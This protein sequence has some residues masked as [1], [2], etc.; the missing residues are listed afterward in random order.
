MGQFADIYV[1]VRTRSKQKATA[2]LNHFLPQRIESAGEYEYPQYSRETE[3]E[4]DTVEEL[5][6]YLETEKSAAY[7]LYWRSTDETNPNKHGMLFFTK[8]GA[9]IFGISRDAYLEEDLNTRNED[10]C[11]ELMKGYFQTDLGYIT[12]EGVP[13]DTYR[14][15]VEIANELGNRK[16]H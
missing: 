3:K 9:L 13:P 7:N 15:F 6:S 10:E 1:A 16:K 11:L 2:F 4:F 5:L 12:Y 14:E 8:D